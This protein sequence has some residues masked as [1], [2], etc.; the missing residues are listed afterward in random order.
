MAAKLAEEQPNPNARVRRKPHRMRP[1]H[2]DVVAALRRC[3]G[4]YGPASQLLGISRS[5]LRKQVQGNSRL[6]KAVADLH[7]GALDTVEGVLWS[8]AVND[9]DVKACG[10]ILAARGRARG[11]GL[12]KGDEA[13]MGDQPN[14]GLVVSVTIVGFESGKFV[15]DD[16][17]L[18]IEHSLDGAVHDSRQTQKL[19]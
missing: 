6:S 18:T 12:L 10:M 9:R 3:G 17:P 14:T 11:Y 2:D 16:E 5:N 4:F 13:V 19:D 7:E 1:R 8:R 15:G